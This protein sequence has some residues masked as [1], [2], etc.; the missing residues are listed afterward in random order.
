MTKISFNSDLN[1][2]VQIGDV[3]YYVLPT[4]VGGFNQSTAT[5]TLIGTITDLKSNFIKIDDPVN[6][7]PDDSFIMFRKNDTVNDSSV[8]G[9]YVEVTLKNSSTSE[10]ELFSV[11]SEVA[12]SSK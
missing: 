3:A 1:E 5:P 10:A 6:N 11:G 2:S 9:E 12:L 7:P 8:I 4:S